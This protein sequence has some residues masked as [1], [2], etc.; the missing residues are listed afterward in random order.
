MRIDD[1][2]KIAAQL[3]SAQIQT[4]PMALT[5]LPDELHRLH[6]HIMQ[7]QVGTYRPRWQDELPELDVLDQEQAERAPLPPKSYPPPTNPLADPDVS[8]EE[9]VAGTIHYDRLN[10]LECGAGVKLIKSHLLT[11]HN[12]MTWHEYLERHGLPDSYPSTTAEH[13]ERQRAGAVASRAERKR[14]SGGDG[15]AQDEGQKKYQP[16]SATFGR[17]KDVGHDV[18]DAGGELGETG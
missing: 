1:S 6:R 4:T 11:S 8:V 14:K 9:K 2:L 15:D 17:G 3:M 7:M 16:V 18:G 12:K 10:C 5:D 13:Q